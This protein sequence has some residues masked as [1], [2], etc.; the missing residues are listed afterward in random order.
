MLF[1]MA[2]IKSQEFPL[3]FVA[4]SESHMQFYVAMLWKRSSSQHRQRPVLVQWFFK[5]GGLWEPHQGLIASTLI[6]PPLIIVQQQ[7]GFKWPID[8]RED[9]WVLMSS[10]CHSSSADKPIKWLTQAL[11]K[12]NNSRWIFPPDRNLILKYFF[13]TG[14]G[15]IW[16]EK[17]SWPIISCVARGE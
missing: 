17:K 1:G 3:L 6:S 7:H 11:A 14:L 10:C 4:A 5:W 2:S 8:R 16:G 12:T 13:G 9:V 15:R